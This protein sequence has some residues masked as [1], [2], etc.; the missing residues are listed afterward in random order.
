MPETLAD[1]TVDGIDLAT[2]TIP[3][4]EPESDGTLEWDSTTIVVV[5][6][7]GGGRTGLGYTYGPEVVG[8]LIEGKLADIV[9]GADAL[10]PQRTWAAM[11][12]A[13]R[14]AGQAG[15]GALAVSAVDVA[16]HDLRARLLEVPLSKAL[17]AFRDAVPIYG[18]GGFCTY[19]H[20]RLQEQLGGWA[21]EGIPRVKMKVARH[22][23]EDPGRIAAVREAIGPDV[24]LMVD[25]NGAFNPT[26]AIAAAE[27]YAEAGIGYFEEPVTSDD[28]TGMARVRDHAP[29]G[30]AIAAGEYAWSLY[31]VNRLLEAQAVDIAQADITRCG[32]LTELVRIDG[33]CKA[34][35]LPFSAHCAPALSAHAGCVM[36]TLV[37]L[38]YFHDHVRIE[39]TLFDG[40]PEPSGGEL[41]PDPSAP[42]NGLELKRADAE[43]FRA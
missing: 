16:L 17:G 15:I 42:G 11:R 24:E 37:H 33:L 9:Q 29:P 7:H 3:T 27:R 4:D 10:T 40:V 34:R 38:E 35:S 39:H 1:V 21:S 6:V 23:E 18:S 26:E 20:E 14:N 13:L 19:S 41:R 31:G 30:M 8:G 43:R 2:Y 36:E 5:E 28:P 22:P 32:G 25:A 12:R